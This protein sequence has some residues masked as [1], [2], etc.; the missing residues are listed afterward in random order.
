MFCVVHD[1]EPLEL[2]DLFL[3]KTIREKLCDILRRTIQL[4]VVED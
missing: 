4:F 3:S 2:I 1:L